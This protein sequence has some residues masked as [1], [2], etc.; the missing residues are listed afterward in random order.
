M[1]EEIIFEK[2]NGGICLIRLNTPPMNLQTLDSMHLLYDII[3][4]IE[5]DAS[6]SA[7]VLS[8]GEG[9][10]FCAGSDVKEFP[11]L[12]GNFVEEKLR[13]ENMV[14]DR[15]SELPVP[16][17]CA[18]TGSALG[19]GLELALCCDFRVMAQEASL[20]LPEIMLGNFP[21]SGGPMR[22]CRLLGPYR[23]AELMSM[24]ARLSAHEALALGL[25]NRVEQRRDVERCALELAAEL[26]QK[27]AAAM[28][29]I[30]YLVYASA[31]QSTGQAAA[32]AQ[33]FARRMEGKL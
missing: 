18:I 29:A 11:K 9:R 5:A 20:S 22:M 12:R 13:F 28:R 8:G 30:K 1:A 15:L 6:I 24:S 32:S 27:P 21:G 16:T 25:V 3:T 14:F 33:A 4:G 10:V 19:G 31:H 17:V 23:A 26:A 2:L 7:V